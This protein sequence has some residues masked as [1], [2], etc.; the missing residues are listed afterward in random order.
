MQH[1]P[2][3]EE[4]RL[5][6]FHIYNVH[7]VSKLLLL[8]HSILSSLFKSCSISSHH[9]CFKSSCQNIFS[10]IYSVYILQ[11]K[12]KICYCQLLLVRNRSHSCL[13]KTLIKDFV[14]VLCCALIC[15]LN[16]DCVNFISKKCIHILIEVIYGPF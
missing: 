13:V 15:C 5:H 11:Q 4:V 1:I 2:H 9:N 10:G 6:I 16:M 7:K 14:A 8:I 12:F 3:E